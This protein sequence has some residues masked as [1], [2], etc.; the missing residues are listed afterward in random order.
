MGHTVMRA[1]AFAFLLVMANAVGAGLVG[2]AAASL[3]PMEDDSVT[4]VIA[5]GTIAAIAVWAAICFLQGAIQQAAS[6]ARRRKP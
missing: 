6:V 3:P 4:T 2:L 1:A 5:W